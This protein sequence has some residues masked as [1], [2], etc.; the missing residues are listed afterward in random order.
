MKVMYHL[1]KSISVIYIF[2]LLIA[3]M[4]LVAQEK[5]DA[6]YF[7]TA[8]VMFRN[9]DYTDAITMYDK[10]IELDDTNMKYY[11]QRGFCKNLSSD[12]EGA[13]L[14]FTSAIEIKSDH[15]WAYVSRGSSYN[16]LKYYDKAISDFNKALELN[17][18]N[19]EAYNNRGFSKKKLGDKSG[20]CKDWKTSKKLGNEEARIILKNN[21]C[22]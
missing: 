4:S 15:P 2:V 9:A 18:D 13:I 22:K 10:A 17:P 5:T 21:Y 7:K 8:E 6:D 11:L 14:D 1:N 20:A 12:F 16:K 19:Q 3:P